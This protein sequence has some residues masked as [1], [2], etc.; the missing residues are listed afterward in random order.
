[1]NWP[2]D[3]S[4]WCSMFSRR[5]LRVPTC[6]LPSQ[7]RFSTGWTWSLA[8]RLASLSHAWR[9][10]PGLRRHQACGIQPGIRTK[11]AILTNLYL[12][13]IFCKILSEMLFSYLVAK[14]MEFSLQVCDRIGSRLSVLYHLGKQEGKGWQGN[15]KRQTLIMIKESKLSFADQDIFSYI[16]CCKRTSCLPRLKLL[17]RMQVL[18]RITLAGVV[19]ILIV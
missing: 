12:T 5:R 2:W 1:M 6:Q 10:A 3:L 18:G 19:L 11:G 14:L 9:T 13:S 7:I 4:R 8:R 17:S 16:L 15:L